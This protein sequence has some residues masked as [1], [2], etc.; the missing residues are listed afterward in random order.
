M[1]CWHSTHNRWLGFTL[2]H[3]FW[4]TEHTSACTFAV[5]ERRTTRIGSRPPETR[6]RRG[7]VAAALSC[8]VTRLCLC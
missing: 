7:S 2:S 8:V 5:G 1:S 6:V 4:C 3:G